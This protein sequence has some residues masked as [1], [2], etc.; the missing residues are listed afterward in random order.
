MNVKEQHQNN[1]AAWNEAAG[2]YKK[3]FETSVAFLKAGGQNFLPPEYDFIGDLKDWCTS[4]IHLQ[5]AA[6]QDTLSLWNL[7]AREVVGVDI[8]DEMI[9]LATRK[10]EAIGAPATWYRCDL[11]ETPA[12]LD[13]TADLVY[14]GRGALN[15]QMDIE[16]WASVVVRLLKPGGKLYLFEGHPYMWVWDLAAETYVLDAEY[17][18]YFD[19]AAHMDQGWPVEYIN[20]DAIGEKEKQAQKYE[21]QWT[22]S[23]IV[24]AII[25]A[26]LIIEKLGEHP[27]PYW[28]M[29][30]NMPK[31][32]LERLPQTFSVLARK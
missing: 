14:T 4:A 18:N 27:D 5:C 13:N 17:G 3:D 19:N 12:T 16:A 32:M 20:A 28:E 11:L 7:G 8:S 30:P 6:G 25:G 10:G 29:F 9:L 22:V 21:R 2:Q 26:G 23:Q 15:W 1:R 31:E 24:N